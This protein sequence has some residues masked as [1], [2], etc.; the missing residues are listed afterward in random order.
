MIYAAASDGVLG[1]VLGILSRKRRLYAPVSTGNGQYHLETAEQ[2]DPDRHTVAPY[3]T[4]EPLKQLVFPPREFL[5][6]LWTEE[7]GNGIEERIVIGVKNC[8]LSAL[9]IHDYVFRDSEP[10][11]SRYA[12]L[13]EST[14]IVS[15]DCTDCLPVCFCPAVGEQ[16]YPQSG[17]DINL[18]RVGEA[19][20]V[21]TGSEKGESALAAA[22]DLM[23]EAT[24][25][26]VQQRDESRKAMYTRVEQQA[27]E[28]GLAPG[29]D[30][31]AAFQKAFE[32]ELWADFA[33]DCVE[34][35]ACNFVCCTC[36]CFLLGDGYD[37]DSL[38]ARVR[39]W[40]SCLFRNFARVAGGANPREH[41]AARLRNRF[42]KKFNFFVEILGA[43]A[44]NGCG[45]CIEACM[46]KIDIRKVLRRMM[47]DES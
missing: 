5:G 11:D 21:E 31:R 45:R 35:G 37:A 38:P 43:P 1:E 4:V 47:L 10:E 34:C 14:L 36:H 15:A 30:Y 27:K 29:S 17:F 41:R 23:E 19:W 18:S 22:R 9:R 24:P 26:M 32:S 2:W 28:S 6:R 20:L 3:R 33:R 7:E 13:R 8:D 44:C 12:R 25:E 39:E 46:G 40:D 42:D 16:P